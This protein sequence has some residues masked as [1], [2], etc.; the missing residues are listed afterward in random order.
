M[1]SA[2]ESWTH[3]MRRFEV[4]SID[5][6]LSSL[7]GF[8]GQDYEMQI[9]VQWCL[10]I[11][12]LWNKSNLVYVLFGREK[13]AWYTTFVWNTTRVLELVLVKMSPDTARYS[14][15]QHQLVSTRLFSAR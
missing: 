5:S 6:V 1:G 7:S 10:G 14:P 4:S 15:P 9:H 13:F 11:R 3:R 12:P 2:T 8:Y